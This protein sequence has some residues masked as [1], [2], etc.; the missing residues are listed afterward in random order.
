MLLVNFN[1]CVKTK[2]SCGSTKKQ[3]KVR[4]AKMKKIAPGM[5]F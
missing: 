2:T 5:A 1:S 4:H 3:A